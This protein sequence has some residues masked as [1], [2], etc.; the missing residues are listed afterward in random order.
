MLLHV[1]QRNFTERAD[2][3]FRV[4]GKDIMP[5]TFDDIENYELDKLTLRLEYSSKPNQ[6]LS[7]ALKQLIPL[8]EVFEVTIIDDP[9]SILIDPPDHIVTSD[10]FEP[11]LGLYFESNKKEFIIYRLNSAI[12]FPLRDNTESV[13]FLV[14]MMRKSS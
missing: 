4:H 2:E 8:S 6:A 11:I 12:T 1:E 9:M 3:V 7:G 10:G 13:N 5:L 14:Q